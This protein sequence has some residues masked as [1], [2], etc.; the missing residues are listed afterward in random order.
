MRIRTRV[1]DG[2]HH[3]DNDTGSRAS[4]AHV[5]GSDREQAKDGT[6]QR[7]SSRD[8]TLEFFIHRTFPMAGHDLHPIKNLNA[9]KEREIS[10]VVD[11]S[12]A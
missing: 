12:A 11:P 9:E 7:G 2:D 3:H 6:P 8:D 4:C 1:D 10:R 5:V